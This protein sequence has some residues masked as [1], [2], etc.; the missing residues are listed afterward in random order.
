[1]VAE[2]SDVN[3][4]LHDVATYTKLL[5]ACLHIVALSACTQ[6]TGQ[7]RSHESTHC[8]LNEVVP[9]V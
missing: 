4:R 3:E 1:M 5:V 6:E 7:R 2:R 8:A 9:H